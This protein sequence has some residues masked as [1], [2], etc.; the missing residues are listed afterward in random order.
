LAA[1]CNQPEV[2]GTLARLLNTR[3]PLEHEKNLKSSVINALAETASPWA[4]AELKTFL[5][6]RQILPTGR[7]LQ[8]KIA[9]MHSLSRYVN[10]AA[11]ALAEEISRLS[12]GELALAAQGV[13]LELKAKL[14]S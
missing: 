9:A 6:S 1:K 2:I 12:T 7:L 14:S 4:L 13:A 3:L 5:L 10:P 11:M 8:L